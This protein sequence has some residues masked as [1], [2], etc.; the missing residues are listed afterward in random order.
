MTDAEDTWSYRGHLRDGESGH[1][2]TGGEV[3]QDCLGHGRLWLPWQLDTD[4]HW[5]T[6]YS[7]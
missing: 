5:V 3:K 4:A 6:E 1:H 2:T 7:T